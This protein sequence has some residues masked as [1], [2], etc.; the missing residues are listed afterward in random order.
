MWRGSRDCREVLNFEVA[1]SGTTAG[2]QVF[3]LRKTAMAAPHSLLHIASKNQGAAN[4]VLHAWNLSLVP[5]M[6]PQ[7]ATSKINISGTD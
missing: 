2:Q 3:Q 6:V 7:R 1:G 5:A 4:A